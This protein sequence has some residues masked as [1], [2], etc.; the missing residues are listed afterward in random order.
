[1]LRAT[2]RELPSNARCIATIAPD[3]PPPPGKTHRFFPAYL[4]HT[5]D[6]PVQLFSL[7]GYIHDDAQCPDGAYALLGMRC[8]MALREG[9]TE[10]PPPS[11]EV[12]VEGRNDFLRR[13]RLESTIAWR[14]SNRGD[15]SFPMY[16][17]SDELQI[18]L[19]KI[20][21]PAP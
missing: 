10:G 13:W 5:E 9:Q 18:G 12:M 21:G 2:D 3:D 15:V 1:M 6:A 16:P 8:Y 4:F 11:G 17:Q 7:S 14:A 20:L 19:Y